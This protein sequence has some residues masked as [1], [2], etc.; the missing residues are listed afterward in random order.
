MDDYQITDEV[1]CPKCGNEI[2]HYRTCQNFD[3]D[4]GY[5]DANEKDPIN[6]MPGEIIYKCKQ[7]NGTGIE[8]WCPKCG[9]GL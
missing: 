8:S 9:A 6:Y 1:Q 3:C 7:C 5:C 2:T 4:D